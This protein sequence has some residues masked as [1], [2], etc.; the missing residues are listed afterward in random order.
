MCP[1]FCYL[2]ASSLLSS[3]PTSYQLR[4]QLSHLLHQKQ[5]GATDTDRWERECLALLLGVWRKELALKLPKTPA[6]S[7]TPRSPPKGIA[8]TKSTRHSVLKQIYGKCSSEHFVGYN[9]H[10][11]RVRLEGKFPFGLNTKR[12]YSKNQDDSQHPI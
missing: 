4:K 8:G 1:Q 2:K 6:V 5:L 11:Q 7:R 9:K 10:T 12:S 3:D